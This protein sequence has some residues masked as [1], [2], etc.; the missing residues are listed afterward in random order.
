MPVSIAALPHSLEY[1]GSQGVAC[2][3][4]YRVEDEGE[5]R[6]FVRGP[7]AARAGDTETQATF[8]DE[9]EALTTTGVETAFLQRFLAADLVQAHPHQNAVVVGG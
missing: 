7:V 6:A 8:E 3:D 4:G 5:F 9:L 2:W 1:S